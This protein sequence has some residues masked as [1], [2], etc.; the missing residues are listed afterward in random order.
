MFIIPQPTATPGPESDGAAA[1]ANP[2]QLPAISAGEGPQEQEFPKLNVG[3]A[4]PLA[5]DPAPVEAPK[6]DPTQDDPDRVIHII[7]P[8]GHELETPMSMV[9]DD[10]MCPHCSAQFRLRFEDSLEHKEEKKK[11]ALRRETAFERGAL[12]WAIS[13]A[14]LVG[15]GIIG[16]VIASQMR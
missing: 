1:A 14:V 11:E 4:D 2:A 7:C 15:V 16:L 12:K 6:L 8:N 9:G 3:P 10:A 5:G 13:L